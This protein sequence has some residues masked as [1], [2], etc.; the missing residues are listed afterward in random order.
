[1]SGLSTE[2]TM[3]HVQDGGVTQSTIYLLHL[4]FHGLFPPS[5]ASRYTA[6]QRIDKILRE[7]RINASRVCDNHLRE[8]ETCT[9]E[10]PKIAPR[11]CLDH[12]N[13]ARQAEVLDSGIQHTTNIAMNTSKV[14]RRK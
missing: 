14:V 6:A 10:T 12:V 13:Y 5:G 1:M 4:R 2:S 3:R 11:V 9:K 7:K 8:V